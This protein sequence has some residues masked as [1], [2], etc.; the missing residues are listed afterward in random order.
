MTVSVSERTK[1]IGIMKAIGAK[2]SDVLLIFLVESGYTGLSGG[3]I[4]GAFGFLLGIGIG[5][6]IG[7]PVSLNLGLWARVV[8]FAFL[9]STIAGAWPAWRAANLNPVDALRHE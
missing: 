7:L 1:E 3:F 6:F 4:G 9:T 8:L 2:N 5:G